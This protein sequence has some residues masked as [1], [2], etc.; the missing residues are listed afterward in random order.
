MFFSSQ[1]YSTNDTR[2]RKSC[3]ALR[4]AS[5]PRTSRDA[6]NVSQAARN[7]TLERG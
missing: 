5:L 1:K 4:K 7:C 6:R 3:R 2:Y